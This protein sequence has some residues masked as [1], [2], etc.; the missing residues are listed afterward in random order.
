[1]GGV[2]AT[3]PKRKARAKTQGSVTPHQH[4]NRTVNVALPKAVMKGNRLGLFCHTVVHHPNLSGG[5]RSGMG[6]GAVELRPSPIG[7]EI[8]G[9]LDAKTHHQAREVSAESKVQRQPSSVEL[10]VRV[11]DVRW[12]IDQALTL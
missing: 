6:G 4:P 2:Q 7:G 9:M 12:V 8:V 1:M 10:V 3:D 11:N 5:I